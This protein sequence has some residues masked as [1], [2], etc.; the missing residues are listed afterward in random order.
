M[1]AHIKQ[2]IADLITRI[3]RAAE[4]AGR[5]PAEITLVAVS[6]NHPVEAV[7]AAAECGLTVMGESRVQEAAPK[8]K[9]LGE[10]VTWH[11][12]GHLQTNKAG[13]AARLFD[14]IQSVD[15]Y[16]LASVLDRAA[17][18]AGKRLDCLLEV[19]SSG[20]SA[21]YGIAP[22]NASG[23]ISGICALQNLC[24][25]GVMTIGP[26]TDNE[27]EIRNAF[28]ITRN[29]FDKA[30]EIAGDGITVLSMGMS[31]DFETAIDEG[32][33]MVRIGTAIFGSRG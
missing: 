28:R 3:A 10:A 5:D 8:I 25:C 12:I 20:E 27:K 2:N 24:L 13:R 17:G 14:M 22:V 31:D 33:T 1:L 9:R 30:Q 29:V 19:N 6:K 11:M 15:S 21:K 23:L 32:S 16:K 7:A 4:K 18:E 26:F